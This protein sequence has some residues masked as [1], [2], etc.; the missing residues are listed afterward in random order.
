M[1]KRTPKTSAPC[2]V[3]WCHFLDACDVFDREPTLLHLEAKNA[4]FAVWAAL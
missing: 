4:A 3:A 2:D 1:T